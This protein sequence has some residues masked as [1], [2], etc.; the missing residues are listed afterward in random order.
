MQM[1]HGEVRGTMDERGY[2]VKRD[3]NKQPLWSGRG[4]P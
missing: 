4:P 1:R 3:L 2:A